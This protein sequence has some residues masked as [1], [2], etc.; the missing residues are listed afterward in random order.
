M[1]DFGQIDLVVFFIDDEIEFLFPLHPNFA[2]GE[3]RNVV[4]ETGNIPTV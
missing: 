2:S 1:A 4:S 3:S